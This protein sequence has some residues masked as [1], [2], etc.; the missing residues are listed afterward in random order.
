VG[1]GRVVCIARLA[2]GWTVRGSNSGAGEIF[3][4][5]P[6]RPWPPPGFQCNCYRVFLGDKSVGTWRLPPTPSSVKVK[7]RV[8]LYFYSPSGAFVAGYKVT[9]TFYLMAVIT[10]GNYHEGHYHTYSHNGL[11]CTK[12]CLQLYI[13]YHNITQMTRLCFIYLSNRDMYCV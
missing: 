6:D 5:P 4:T 1:W 10:T 11:F 9:F 2:A 12:R 3:H 8:E 7:E 13:T